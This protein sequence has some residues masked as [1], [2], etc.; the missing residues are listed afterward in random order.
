MIKIDSVG[1][2]T[3]IL[4]VA[5]IILSGN[6][7]S[8]P[9]ALAIPKDR[10]I[11]EDYI[12]YIEK[13]RSESNEV[14]LEKTAAYFL[15][16]PYVEHS[17]DN[18]DIEVLT[19]NLR[20][21]DCFTFVETVIALTLTTKAEKPNY[22]TFTDILHSIRYRDNEI[23]GYHSRLHYTTDWIY[24]NE[25]NGILKNISG[26]IGGVKDNKVVNFMS[27]HRASYKQ[28]KSDNDLLNEII[29]VEN[30]INDREGFYYLPKERVAISN[31]LIPQMSIICFTTT[32]EGLD[33]THAGF[34]YRS[35]GELKLIHASSVLKKVLVLEQ[36]LSDYCNGRKTCTGIIIA[37][38][39]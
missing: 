13:W 14:I 3:F 22:N 5:F 23:S 21:F 2:N 17:L 19:V 20:E 31:Y 28:I 27:T 37:K 18:S 34:A 32:I 29:K 7:A 12:S 35:E 30:Q 24:E 15:G 38:I 33:V 36:S 1:K 26:E 16:N 25:K 10:Q 39:Q 9:K 6:L 11:F 4:I 8:Q